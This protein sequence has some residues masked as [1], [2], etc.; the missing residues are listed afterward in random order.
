MTQEPVFLVKLH[1]TCSTEIR[2]MVPRVPVPQLGGYAARCQFHFR[3]TKVTNPAE[4]T[5]S[6]TERKQHENESLLYLS[7]TMKSSTCFARG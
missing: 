6:V 2:R 7:W 1:I 4:M 5:A 3:V